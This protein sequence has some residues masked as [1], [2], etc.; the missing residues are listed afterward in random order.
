MSKQLMRNMTNEDL[1]GKIES[2]GPE[3]FFL[4]Y[5]DPDSIQDEALRKDVRTLRLIWEEIMSI[6]DEL[7]DEMDD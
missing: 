3:Y 5:I 1:L 2:E 6:I 4:E 7:E